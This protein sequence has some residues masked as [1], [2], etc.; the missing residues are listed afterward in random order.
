[1]LIIV[2]MAAL[3][4]ALSPPIAY[5]ELGVFRPAVSTTVPFSLT[6]YTPDHVS[7]GH[8]PLAGDPTPDNVPNPALLQFEDPTDPIRDCTADIRSVVLGL[9]L[10]ADYTLGLRAIGSDG[11]FSPWGMATP[12]FRRAPRGQPCPGGQPGVLIQGEADLNG[13]PVRMT[14]CVNH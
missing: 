2:A 6:R 12:S 5:Y 3:L 7:C 13:Q 9:P 14:L 4:R 1:M 11:K 8:I 10:G